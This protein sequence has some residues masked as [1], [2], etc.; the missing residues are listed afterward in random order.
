ML[1]CMILSHFSGKATT[2]IF[3]CLL[4]RFE[5][6]NLSTDSSYNKNIHSQTWC[7]VVKLFVIHFSRSSDLVLKVGGIGPGI[8]IMETSFCQTEFG[9][10]GIGESK[11]MFLFQVHDWCP[12][13]R[14]LL[15]RLK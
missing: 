4:I 3:F 5:R 9:I 11:K 12:L 6:G 13:N 10:S 2:D 7:L 8:N 15:F 14:L 1:V